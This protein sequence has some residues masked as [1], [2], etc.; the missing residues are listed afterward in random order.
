MLTHAATEHEALGANFPK[1]E[2]LQITGQMI[3]VE[4]PTSQYKIVSKSQ[5]GKNLKLKKTK[6]GKAVGLKV[7]R[8]GAASIVSSIKLHLSPSSSSIS[9]DRL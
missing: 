1:K 5:P 8:T 6:M 3:Q 9:M 4:G 7:C 2:E